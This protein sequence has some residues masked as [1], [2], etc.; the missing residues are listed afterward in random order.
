MVCKEKVNGNIL[1][2]DGLTPHIVLQL[3]KGLTENQPKKDLQ[4]SNRR[5]K[6]TENQTSGIL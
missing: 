2:L 1:A 4:F 5:A 3:A 6:G